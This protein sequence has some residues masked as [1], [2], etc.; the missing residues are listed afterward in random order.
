MAATDRKFTQNGVAYLQ[1]EWFFNELPSDLAED[2]AKH[3]VGCSQSLSYGCVQSVCW[4]EVPSVYVICEKDLIIRAAIAELMLA[5]T[6]VDWDIV[7]IDADHSPFLGMP[8]RLAAIVRWA[9]GERD[10]GLDG[11]KVD[12]K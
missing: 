9:S 4:Y 7:R 10:V 12:G 11:V 6:K 5:G 1:P 8:N 2:A 3:L